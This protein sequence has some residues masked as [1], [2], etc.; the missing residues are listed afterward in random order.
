MWFQTQLFT[1]FYPLTNSMKHSSYSEAAT[2]LVQKIPAFYRNQSFITMFTRAC[3]CSISWARW[4]QST[5]SQPISLRSIL[6]L[7][8]HLYKGLPS[9]F[10]PSGFLTKILYALLIFIQDTWPAHFILL[11]LITL[12][13]FREVYKFWSLYLTAFSS[14]PPLPSFPQQ[15]V[16]KHLQS[17]FLA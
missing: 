4:I 2:Q 5:P 17:M 16:L 6:T 14:L 10:L 13:I 7:S 1:S 11:D 3:H 9:A 12:L 15:P 8:S